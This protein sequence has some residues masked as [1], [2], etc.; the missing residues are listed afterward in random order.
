M[1]LGSGKEKMRERKKTE[2][3]Q[4]CSKNS[5][6]M[7]GV[8]LDYFEMRRVKARIHQP[9]HFCHEPLQKRRKE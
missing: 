8:Q 1:A 9:R 3:S 6:A 4:N 5:H 2:K 7:Q